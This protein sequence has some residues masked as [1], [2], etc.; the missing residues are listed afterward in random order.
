MPVTHRFEWGWRVIVLGVFTTTIGTGGIAGCQ[1]PSYN[2]GEESS[3]KTVAD[4]PNRNHAA[5]V[6]RTVEASALIDKGKLD[7]AERTLRSALDADVTHGPAHNN[8]GL[9]Y[10][11]QKKFYLAAWEF[12]YAIKLM[13][14]APQPL[15]NLGL[16]LERVGK[17]DQAIE[18]YE[19]ARKLAPDHAEYVAN[20]A[21]AKVR[22]GDTDDEV[23]RLLDNV[24]LKDPR[25][26]WSNWARQK[27][28][29]MES[30][31]S[32]SHSPLPSRD[33]TTAAPDASNPTESS[34]PPESP[35]SPEPPD[36][37]TPQPYAQPQ[38]ETPSDPQSDPVEE[39][40]TSPGSSPAS[41]P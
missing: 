7:N 37:Q 26:D 12:Q 40:P 8:L 30:F 22:R 28:V 15:N 34:E 5:A 39:P 2:S 36:A 18:V 33:T 31:Q 23:R 11:K 17:L 35:E 25:P 3:Y 20:L 1:A 10:F 9:V 13:P 29:L 14:D 19:K 32:R 4:S 21:R 27:L 41:S 24:V 6:A 38:E 16:V